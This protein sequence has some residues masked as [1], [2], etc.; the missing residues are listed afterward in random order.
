MDPDM[1]ANCDDFFNLGADFVH[2]DNDYFDDL[3][4]LGCGEPVASCCCEDFYD[5][6]DVYDWCD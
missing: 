4:C 2:I 6:M 1:L 3:E 5:D